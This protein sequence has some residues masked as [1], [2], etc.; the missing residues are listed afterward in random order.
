MSTII[1]T[2]ET[3][4]TISHPPPAISDAAWVPTALLYFGVH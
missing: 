1:V 2:T 3:T 4:Q